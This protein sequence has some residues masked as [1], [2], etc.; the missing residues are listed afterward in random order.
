MWQKMMSDSR[1]RNAY[2]RLAQKQRTQKKAQQKA[3]PG[4]YKLRPVQPAP[5]APGVDRNAPATQAQ[6]KLQ[7]AYNTMQKK[8]DNSPAQAAYG[9][10]MQTMARNR[11]TEQRGMNRPAPRA[12][13]AYS[14]TP[15]R[16]SIS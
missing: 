3:A 14:V 1:I 13:G 15:M 12:S 16:N 11:S 6:N 8:R 7:G 4:P 5:Q 2:R 10:A 9:R